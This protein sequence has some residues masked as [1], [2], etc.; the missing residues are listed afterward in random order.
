MT[1]PL[2]H[3]RFSGLKD[4]R[5]EFGMISITSA[6]CLESFRTV[7]E[8]PCGYWISYGYGDDRDRWVHKTSRRRFAYPSKGEAW[9]SFCRRTHKFVARAEATLAHANAN[10]LMVNNMTVGQAEAQK[11]GYSLA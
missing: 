1:L 8:T 2:Y 6:L 7:G 5:I 11:V 10:L 3:Y 9:E 4:N